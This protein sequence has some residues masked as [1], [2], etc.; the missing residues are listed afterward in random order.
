MDGFVSYVNLLQ[1][2]DAFGVPDPFLILI[3]GGEAIS[4]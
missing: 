3:R 2:D 4:L 1:F